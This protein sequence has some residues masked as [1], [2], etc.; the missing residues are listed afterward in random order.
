MPRS[1]AVRRL[2]SRQAYGAANCHPQTG[3]G[4]TAPRS[5]RFS[6][7]LNPMEALPGYVSKLAGWFRGEVAV[8]KAVNVMARRSLAKVDGPVLV[9]SGLIAV[10]RF[11]ASGTRRTISL[12]YPGELFHPVRACGPVVLEAVSNSVLELAPQSHF[13]AAISAAPDMLFALNQTLNR[14]RAIAYEWLA[15][16]GLRSS[17]ERLAHFLCETCVRLNAD[18]S[19]LALPFNQWQLA[20]ITAQTS[21]H[22]NRV[23]GKLDQSGLIRRRRKTFEI[24]DWSALARLGEFHPGYLTD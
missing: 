16:I 20:E 24:G 9:Q 21:V 23:L 18:P 5:E 7:K 2:V 1:A 10:T 22:V 11:E 14:E 13:D 12:H 4:R 19:A 6:G 8:E 15:R 3:N 17:M